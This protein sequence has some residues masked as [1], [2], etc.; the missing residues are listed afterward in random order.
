MSISIE[1]Y[2]IKQPVLVAKWVKIEVIG[3]T[4][5]VRAYVRV[6]FYKEKEDMDSYNAQL[7]TEVL[8]IMGEEYAQWGDDDSY[9]ENLVLKKCGL[10]KKV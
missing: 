5:G 3:V 6:S 7:S 4:L 1:D 2:D 10:V 9:L 8:D